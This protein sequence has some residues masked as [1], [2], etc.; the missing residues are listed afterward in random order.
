M[1]IKRASALVLSLEYDDV[2]FHNFV[3]QRTFA[4]KPAALEI[5]RRLHS[6]TAADAACQMFPNHSRASVTRSIQQLIDAGALIEEGSPAA[7]RD[8]A[9]ARAWLWGPWTGAYHF[10]T[11]AGTFV[12]DDASE[13]MQRQLAKV[14]PSPPLYRRNPDPSTALSVPLAETYAEPFLT[15]SRRRTNRVML[16]EPIALAALSDCFLFSMAITAVLDAR[17]IGELPLK[18][19]PSG[20]ARNP[21]E[22]YACIRNVEG[23]APGVYHYSAME[24]SFGR[25]G[26]GPPPP[27]PPLLG[28]QDWT[29]T[30]AAVIFLVANFERTMWKYHSSNAYRVICMEAGHIAQ[31]MLLAATAHGLVA[32]PTGLIDQRLVEQALGLDDLLQAPLYAV[33]IGV[34]EPFSGDLAQVARAD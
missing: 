17:G 2:V 1:R 5:V 15:M 27:F 18:M 22:G 6:W 13:A 8:D 7:Q 32:N 31:N 23:V 9:Y 28:A 24:R 11:Y 29:A 21:F 33:V 16:E 34:P 12:S 10:G 20:G 4:A 25:V 14:S 26:E 3:E 30:A 19:T